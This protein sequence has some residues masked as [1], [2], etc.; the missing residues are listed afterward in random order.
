MNASA[1]EKPADPGSH[2]IPNDAGW[3]L[4][5]LSNLP[6]MNGIDG[7]RFHR[8]LEAGAF[9]MARHCPSISEGMTGRSINDASVGMISTASHMQLAVQ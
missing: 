2:A 1:E 3:P 4:C 5:D 6:A 9:L 7:P 8:Q